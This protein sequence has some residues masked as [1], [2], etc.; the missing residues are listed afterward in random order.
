MISHYHKDSF[1]NCSP[2]LINNDY[3]WPIYEDHW[4]KTVFMTI[5]LIFL[6]IN[7]ALLSGI[8]WYERYGIDAKRTIVNKLFSFGCWTAIQF[9]CLVIIPDLIRYNS[10]PWPEMICWLHLIVKNLIGSQFLLILTATIVMRYICIFLMKNPTGFQDDFWSLFLNIWIVAF[11]FITQFVFVH[12]PGRQVNQYYICLGIS[13]PEDLYLSPPKTNFPLLIIL[14]LGIVVHVLISI[15]IFLF[16]NDIKQHDLATIQKFILN[17]ISI[18][19]LEKHSMTDF[20]TNTRGIISFLETLF[21]LQKIGKLE[22]HELNVYPNNLI[23]NWLQ[24]VN[25][26]IV[27]FT[28]LVFYY[29]RKHS[30]RKSVVKKLKNLFRT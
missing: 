27:M 14:L 17:N 25:F 11:S 10:G 28:T 18:A 9:I 7:T 30:L 8:I 15:K 29:V 2:E 23:L 5:T 21:L 22:P 1:L 20:T 3:F 26:A 19:S 16:R 13:P 6:P 12:M 24:L 4:Y